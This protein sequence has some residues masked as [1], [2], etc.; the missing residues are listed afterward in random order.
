MKNNNNT[1]TSNWPNVVMI[2]GGLLMAILWPLYITLHG[3]TSY[4]QDGRF[5]GGGVLFWGMMMNAPASV[6]FP[7]GL[8]GHYRLLTKDTRR[9]AKIG[10]VLAMIGLVIPAGIDFVM[11]AIGPPLLMPLTTIGLILVA[12]ANRKNAMLPKVAQ[13][14]LLGLGILLGLALPM[15]LIPLAIFDQIEGYRIYGILAHLLFGVGWVVL[16]FSLMKMNH[17]Q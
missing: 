7:L 3:P 14:T 16:G 8:A 9:M 1:T 17:A 6:L 13:H 5:L 11:V 12:V 10:I 4:D 2:A 15:F